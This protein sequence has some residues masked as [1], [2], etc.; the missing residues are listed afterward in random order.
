VTQDRAVSGR[1]DSTEEVAERPPVGSPDRVDARMEPEQAPG[2][3]AVADHP[4]T[5]ARGQQLPAADN[6]VL[7]AGNPSDQPVRCLR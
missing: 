6:S 3:Q 5:E 1:K 2:L 7:P 4:G